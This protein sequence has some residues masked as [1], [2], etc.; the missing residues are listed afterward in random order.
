MN[1]PANTRGARRSRELPP[2]A[3]FEAWRLSPPQADELL[4]PSFRVELGTID[5]DVGFTLCLHGARPHRR[6]TAA[7]AFAVLAAAEIEMDAKESAWR[8]VRAHHGLQLAE[9]LATVAID[10]H[11]RTALVELASAGAV[12]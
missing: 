5:L 9:A 12:W 2:A 10:D 7:D 1:Y 4:A 3:G 8:A 11:L 6:D